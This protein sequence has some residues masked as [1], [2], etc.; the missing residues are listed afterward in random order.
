MRSLIPVR[1]KSLQTFQ[2]FQ[3]S[4]FQPVA[5]DPDPKRN[6]D[7]GLLYELR[8][9]MH[10]TTRRRSEFPPHMETRENLQ[11]SLTLAKN[12]KN[13]LRLFKSALVALE[14]RHKAEERRPPFDLG[15]EAECLICLESI[16]NPQTQRLI[17]GHAYHGD[18]VREFFENWTYSIL[19][20]PVCR[21]ILEADDLVDGNNPD[22]TFESTRDSW[23]ACLEP[24]VRLQV[25]ME[26]TS[27][28]ASGVIEFCETRLSSSEHISS[29]SLIQ[30]EQ[31]T[32]PEL[33][34]ACRSVIESVATYRAFRLGKNELE[35]A[36][37]VRQMCEEDD[38]DF[39]R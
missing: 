26:N 8:S 12:L 21:F 3:V 34:S 39:L 31:R 20:C 28:W 15:P 7:S 2:L 18:C 32:F 38:I 5:P 19:P 13:Q 29:E 36:G 25:A 16:E 33:L 27:S 10:D 4:N 35:V 1:V 11:R 37:S 30:M 22:G 6:M 24:I 9:W 17:C 14:N 23:Q